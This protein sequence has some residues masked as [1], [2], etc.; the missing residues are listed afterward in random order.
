M[1]GVRAVFARLPRT[2][3]LL[4]LGGA[5]AVLLGSGVLS[6]PCPFHLLTGWD[7]PGCGG[8]RMLVSLLRGDVLAALRHNAFLLL[9]G[10]PV[11]A[12]TLLGVARSE[13]SPSGRAIFGRFGRVLGRGLLAAV[14]LWTVLR[15]LPFAPFTTLVADV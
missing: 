15:N 5:C 11:A 8:T 14:L 7:C 6:W 13:I 1:I 3:T 9:V 4:G 10:L 12:A 2:G